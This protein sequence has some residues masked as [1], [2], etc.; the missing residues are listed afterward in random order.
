M[1][2]TIL[3]N[4]HRLV[5]FCLLLTAN[6]HLIFQRSETAAEVTIKNNNFGEKKTSS[7]ASGQDIYNV[8]GNGAMKSEIVVAMPDNLEVLKLGDQV[9]FPLPN[10]VQIIGVVTHRYDHPTQRSWTVIGNLTGTSHGTFTL[11]CCWMGESVSC[12]GNVRPLLNS[13]Q[14]ELRRRAS[15]SNLSED[16]DREADNVHVMRLVD[17]NE[18]EDHDGTGLAVREEVRSKMLNDPEWTHSH[19][20]VEHHS[21]HPNFQPSDFEVNFPPAPVGGGVS[22]SATVD[23]NDIIDILVVYTPTARRWAGGVGAMELLIS[24]AIDESNHI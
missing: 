24:M 8:N 18:Y 19:P 14:Y 7:S 10:W 3:S 22:L 6:G 23:S 11:G 2:A 12:V 4:L 9:T 1:R 13:S 21:G 17:T 5:L 16:E 20:T 15:F